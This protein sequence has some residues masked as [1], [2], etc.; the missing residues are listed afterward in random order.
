MSLSSGLGVKTIRKAEIFTLVYTT[1]GVIRLGL[2]ICDSR[3]LLWF[4][5]LNNELLILLICDS[6]NFTMVYTAELP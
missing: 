6:R 3:N 1:S 2:C 4:Y 5:R